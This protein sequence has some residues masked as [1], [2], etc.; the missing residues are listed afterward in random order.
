MEKQ[1]KAIIVTRS[2]YEQLAR[3]QEE[4]HLKNRS[5]AIASLF[6]EIEQLK[7]ILQN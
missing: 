7:A 1:D 3:Y 4:R 2:V 6:R 5:S